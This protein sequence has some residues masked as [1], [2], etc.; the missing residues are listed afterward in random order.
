M[1]TESRKELAIW[2]STPPRLG[3][4]PRVKDWQDFN[5]QGIGPLTSV[6][7]TSGFIDQLVGVDPNL[8]Q[9]IIKPHTA[10]WSTPSGISVRKLGSLLL[11]FHPLHRPLSFVGVYPYFSSQTKVV[12]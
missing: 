2:H 6:E 8:A 9:L 12:E 10:L 4:V 3:S 1:K 7:N 5:L 11:K